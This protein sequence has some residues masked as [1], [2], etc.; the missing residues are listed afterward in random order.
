MTS[1]SNKNGRKGQ[2]IYITETLLYDCLHS[3]AATLTHS[4]LM[5]EMTN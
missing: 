5:K 3:G 2:K 1:Q 4:H